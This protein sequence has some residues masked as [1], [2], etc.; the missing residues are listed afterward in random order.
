MLVETSKATGQLIG[1]LELVLLVAVLSFATA[2]V[3]RL[4]FRGV[5][6]LSSARRSRPTR[7]RSADLAAPASRSLALAL[8]CVLVGLPMIAWTEGSDAVQGHTVRNVYLAGSIRLPVLA[9]TAVPATVT[10]LDPDPSRPTGI[11]NRPSLRYLRRS[12]GQAVFYD[13]TS[14][15]SLRIPSDSIVIV[16]HNTPSV[17]HGC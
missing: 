15:D 5:R 13:V 16:L 2:I 14:H 12:D 8:G 1:A 17:P 4:L 6:A 10:E 7:T 3:A 11:A 9:V